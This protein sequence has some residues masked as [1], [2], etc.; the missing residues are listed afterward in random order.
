MKQILNHSLWIGHAADGRNTRLLLDVGIQAVVQLA[1][2]ELPLAPPRELIYLRFPLLDGED[3]EP[4]LLI[5]AMQTVAR[6][7]QTRIPTLVCCGGGLSRSPAIVAAALALD[8]A[9][10]K[11]LDAWLEKMAHL[12]PI[13]VSPGLWRDILAAYQRV[14]A[15]P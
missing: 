5:Q 8:D 1:L 2:E 7:L 15:S 14:V 6:L 3:N 10:G 13:D 12:G 4:A 11:E 9:D